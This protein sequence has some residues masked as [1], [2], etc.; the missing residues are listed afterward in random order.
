MLMVAPKHI[1]WFRQ[2]LRLT[3]NPALHAACRNNASI[4]PIFIL[5]DE[6][7]GQWKKGAASRW[8]LHH[9]LNS[10]NISLNEKLQIFQGDAHSILL[11]L[12][13]DTQADAIYWNRCYEP[14]RIARDTTIKQSLK[15][16]DIAAHSF[17]SSLLYEP[18]EILKNDGTPYKVFTPYY[19]NGCLK[20][21]KPPRVPL[22]LPDSLNLLEHDTAI[23]IDALQLLPD[24]PWD[25]T[26]QT[27]WAQGEDAAQKRLAHFLDTGLKHYK[28]NRNR[29]DMSGTSG[30]SPYLHHGEISPNQAWYAAQHAIAEQG[31]EENSAVFLSEIGWRE[32]G[33]YLLYHFPIF[34]TEN[35]QPKFD[36]FG[37]NNNTDWLEKWQCGQT[38][39]P[40]VDAGMRQLWQTGWMHNRVRMIV[41]SFLIKDLLI[42]WRE[43]EA[44]FWDTLVDADLASNSTG[45]QWVAGSGADASPYFR[46][47]NP[48]TQGE[49]FDPN[50]DYVRTYVPELAKL[51]KKYI[52]KPWEAST[53]ILEHACIRLGRDYPKPM[54]DHK[55]ARDEALR[56]FKELSA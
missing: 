7:A 35:F 41:G 53:D 28:D 25:G 12:A 10:L 1:M 56:R 20:H 48:I 14:W 42:D 33:Y 22:P 4:L 19:K 38:G 3:D 29:P 44:W 6:H 24:T 37:W 17:N 23:S 45:W 27:C 8:W 46:I 43:G 52:H 32:F 30:L 51:D 54:V 5:D 36:G 16:H 11:Q 9:S 26:M 34:P 49:K 15:Q 55:Q 39:Y 40:I 47:F 13:Q 2:D 50:G 31:C 18:H 21:P